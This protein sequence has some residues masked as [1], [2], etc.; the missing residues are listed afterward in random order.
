VQPIKDG[1]VLMYACSFL[2][3]PGIVAFCF[4]V[5]LFSE[6]LLESTQDIQLVRKAK[7]K[8]RQAG[9]SP[10]KS[11]FLTVRFKQLGYVANIQARIQLEFV[12]EISEFRTV[13][14]R[15]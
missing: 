11:H 8:A 12:W 9:K 15:G 3:T 10:C 5:G 4:A 6:P 13:R 7:R 14:G 2:G 1:Q